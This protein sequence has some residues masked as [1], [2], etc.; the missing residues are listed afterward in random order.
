MTLGNNEEINVNSFYPYFESQEEADQAFSI[1]DRD[2]I[3]VLIKET[4][5]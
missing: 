5:V 2:G 3:F 1:F 4:E